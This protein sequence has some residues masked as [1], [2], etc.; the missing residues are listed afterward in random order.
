MNICLCTAG[1]E[2]TWL[3]FQPLHI[4]MYKELYHANFLRNKAKL[5]LAIA[6]KNHHF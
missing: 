3:P 6:A 5:R 1:N 4:K 2:F